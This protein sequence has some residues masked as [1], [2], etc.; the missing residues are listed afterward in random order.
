MAGRNDRETRRV[1]LH[2][3][4]EEGRRREAN[5]NL[6]TFGGFTSTEL[7]RLPQK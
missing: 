7:Q 1:Q 5:L 6:L 2:E 4:R 3:A